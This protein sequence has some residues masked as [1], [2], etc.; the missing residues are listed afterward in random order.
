MDIILASSSLYRQRLLRRLHI[1]FR[2][3]SPQVE[4]ASLEY[5]PPA[6]MAARLALATRLREVFARSAWVSSTAAAPEP[7]VSEA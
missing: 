2:C 1:P 4:E 7:M 3:L 5:E 6:Q